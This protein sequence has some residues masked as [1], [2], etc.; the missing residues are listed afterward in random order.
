M[1]DEQ[2]GIHVPLNPADEWLQSSADLFEKMGDSERK[3][4]AH[5]AHVRFLADHI[6][7]HAEIDPTPE[8]AHDIAERVLDNLPDS[9]LRAARKT[10]L[11]RRQETDNDRTFSE[12][13]A[14]EEWERHKEW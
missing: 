12:D 11:E 9:E 10:V 5:D 4:R 13:L 7:T 2:D 6:L 3:A 14:A 1:D 8:R